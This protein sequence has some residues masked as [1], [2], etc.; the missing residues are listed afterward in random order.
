MRSVVVTVGLAARFT[1]I[2][3]PGFVGEFSILYRF[4][5]TSVGRVGTVPG[6]GRW[7]VQVLTPSVITALLMVVS[8]RFLCGVR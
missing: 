6:V 2:R 7:F 8:Y 1:R 5:T 3:P 4:G